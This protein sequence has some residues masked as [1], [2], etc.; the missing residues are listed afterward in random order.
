MAPGGLRDGVLPRPGEPDRISAHAVVKCQHPQ[1]GQ[2]YAF[3]RRSV[4][5]NSAASK[6]SP[7]VR[8]LRFRVHIRSRTSRV[9]GGRDRGDDCGRRDRGIG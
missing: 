7:C 8:Y 1:S 9:T 3:R 4:P 2:R 6:A 5:D